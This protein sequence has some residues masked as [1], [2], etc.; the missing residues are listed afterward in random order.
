[1]AISNVVANAGVHGSA[2]IVVR[3]DGTRADRVAV[4]VHNE[5]AIPESLLPHVFD[6]F[7]STRQRE[8]SRGLGLGLFIVREIVHAHGGPGAVSP[9]PPD[10]TTFRTELPR[11]SARRSSPLP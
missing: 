10:G 2:A 9:S 7:L 6:P 1:Q 11:R 3:V 8:P 4:E 5:G